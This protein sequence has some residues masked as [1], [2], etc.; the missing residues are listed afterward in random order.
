MAEIVSLN[1]ARKARTK[2]R[3]KAQ[4]EVNR[5][6][7]GLTKAEKAKAEAD[8][9]LAERRLDGHEREPES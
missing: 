5:V 2:V 4:A 3:D 1:R 8:Q 7:F 9:A 6:R